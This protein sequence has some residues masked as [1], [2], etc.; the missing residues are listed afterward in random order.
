M[1]L[2][3]GLPTSLSQVADGGGWVTMITIAVNLNVDK[4]TTPV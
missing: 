4:T 2:F 3:M 1:K